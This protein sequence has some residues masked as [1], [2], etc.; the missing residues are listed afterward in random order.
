MTSDLAG[1]AVGFKRFKALK[2]QGIW[3]LRV[4]GFGVEDLDF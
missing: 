3:C 4:C 1:R 2:G